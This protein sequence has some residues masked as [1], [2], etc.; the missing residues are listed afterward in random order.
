MPPPHRPTTLRGH[1]FRG[2]DVVSAGLLTP[3][4]LRSRAWRRLYRGVYADSELPPTFGLRIAGAGLLI[5]PSAVY[6]GRT[7]AYLHGAT[8]LVDAR[9]PV[10]VSVPTGVRFGPIA[11]L[12]VRRVLL[13]APDVV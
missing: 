8:N 2:R 4:A 9:A 3:D 7:A 1:V 12:R 11:G 6:S 10:E 5:P 13:P